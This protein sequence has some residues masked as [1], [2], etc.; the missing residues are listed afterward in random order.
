LKRILKFIIYFI[1]LYIIWKNVYYLEKHTHA[2]AR[3][4]ARVCVCVCVHIYTRMCKY[5][6]YVYYIK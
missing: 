5:V 6:L 3:A 4:R 2:H 1:N